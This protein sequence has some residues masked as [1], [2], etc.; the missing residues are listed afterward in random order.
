MRGK[1][2]FDPPWH[3]KPAHLQSILA[4]SGLR[5]R[6][7]ASLRAET[8]EIIFDLA[9]GIRLM[10]G[11]TPAP[12]PDRG[13]VVLIHGW[14]GGMDS[15]YILSAGAHL[16]RQGYGVFRL[17]LRDHGGTHHLNE[18]IFYATLIEETHQALKLAAALDGPSPAYLAGFSLGGNFALRL[19]LLCRDD[20]I[21]NLSKILAVSPVLD[22]AKATRAIDA[23]PL[24]RW[25][26]VKKW[27]Q[28][29]ARKMAVHPHRYDFRRVLALDS[30]GAITNA[31]IRDLG[32][33][34]SAQDYFDRYNITC[35]RLAGLTLSTAIVAAADDPIIPAEDFRDLR[36][37][38]STRLHLHRHGGHSGFIQS[39]S[40]DAWHE[41]FMTQF[42]VG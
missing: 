23:H 16:H 38:P 4:S 24:F 2:G 22:P 32:E 11:Y 36:L 40:F 7:G 17:N 1:Q 34:A 28:S 18:G 29:L 12:S 8:R 41:R 6:K 10:G 33:F 37:G 27:K 15:A 35:D 31:L 5:A 39:W 42:F 3:L 26:F 30:V 13:L 25:Y 20:P 19:G 9:G 14:E 21:P